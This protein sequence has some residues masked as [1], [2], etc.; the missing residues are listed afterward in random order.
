MNTLKLY[1]I[2][3]LLLGTKLSFSQNSKGGS[4]A[5]NEMTYVI[6]LADGHQQI[7]KYPIF[8]DGQISNV[9]ILNRETD[10]D[11]FFSNHSDIK[12]PVTYITLNSTVKKLLSL[13]DL[14]DKFKIDKKYLNDNNY[15]IQVRGSSNKTKERRPE[16]KSWK[17]TIY[18]SENAIKSIS[19]DSI[20]KII[21]L[22]TTD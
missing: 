17:K 7:T 2:V 22:N 16:L 9:E 14:F 15:D 5:K 3:S 4:I 6:E 19:V 8:S 12:G 21:I 1:I 10:K 11:G 20:N 18:S 13:S